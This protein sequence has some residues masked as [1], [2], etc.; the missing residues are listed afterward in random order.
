MTAVWLWRVPMARAAAAT[1]AVMGV[2]SLGV[3]LTVAHTD[4]GITLPWAW[5]AKL[6]LLESVLESR[7]AMGCIPAIAI[8]LALGTDRAIAPDASASAPRPCCGWAGSLSRCCRSRRPHW[9]WRTGPPLR[10]SSPTARGA[11]TSPTDPSSRFRSPGPRMPR[12]CNGRSGRSSGTHRRRLLRRPRRPRG[13]G[14]VRPRRPPDRAAARQGAGHRRGAAVDDDATRATALDDLR[15]WNADVVV[16]PPGKNQQ[17]LHTTIE[18]L[19]GV[20]GRW[21]DGVWAWDVRNLT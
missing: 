21:V 9:K 2:L 17:A 8:L 13:Q 4:T 12:L 5:F 20:D 10:R 16:L 18:R 15:F 3:E 6:P 7:F 11:P 19:L 1:V 14:Q